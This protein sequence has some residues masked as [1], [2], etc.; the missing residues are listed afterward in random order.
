MKAPRYSVFLFLFFFLFRCNGKK[1]TWMRTMVIISNVP[2]WKLL[3]ISYFQSYQKV[4]STLTTTFERH[5]SV[6]DFIRTWVNIRVYFSWVHVMKP[7]W[8][9]VPWKLLVVQKSEPV[10]WRT[11]HQDISLIIVFFFFT[12]TNLVFKFNLVLME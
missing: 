4:Q 9:K 10:L 6:E 2:F 11:L 5:H 7:K 12:E 3:D 8:V 1:K